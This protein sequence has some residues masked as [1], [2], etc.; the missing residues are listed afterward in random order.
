MALDPLIHQETRL[1]LMALLAGLGEG[2]EVEFSWLKNALGLTEGNLASHL[3]KLEEAGYV[4]VRKGFVGRR[5]KT[6]VRLTPQ[7]R[8]AYLAHREAL[9]ALLQGG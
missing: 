9:L 4:A 6:W 7:G 5:P 2:A 8:A 1:R 3:Q